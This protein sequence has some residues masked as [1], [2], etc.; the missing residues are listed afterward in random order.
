MRYSF[1]RAEVGCAD[2]TWITHFVVTQ[3]PLVFWTFRKQPQSA[4]MHAWVYPSLVLGWSSFRRLIMPHT[5]L[6]R[7][8]RVSGVL[9][10]VLY[11]GLVFQVS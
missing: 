11:A 5:G 9:G 3:L 2:L 10:L 6:A 8:V 4:W 7:V 1:P